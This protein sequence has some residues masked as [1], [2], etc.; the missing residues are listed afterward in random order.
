MRTITLT[1]LHKNLDQFL[2]RVCDDNAPLTVA[3]ENSRSVVLMSLEEYESLE[4]TAHLMRS[5]ENARRLLDAMAEVERGGGTER[6]L[7]Q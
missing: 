3:R 5:P 7:I 6:T 2:D 1:E 4:E